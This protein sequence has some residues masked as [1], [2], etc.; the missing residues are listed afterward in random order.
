MTMVAKKHQSNLDR[1]KT[2]IENAYNYFKPNYDRWHE[3]SKF[4]FLTSL[5]AKDEEYLKMVGKPPLECNILEAFISRLRGEFYK[6]EPSIEVM[7]DNDTQVDPNMIKVVEGHIRHILTAANND[8]S[9]Y[10]AYTDML[11]GG[12]SVLEVCTEYSNPTSMNQVIKFGRAFDPTLCGFDPLAR[13]PHKGDGRYCFKIY[14][15]TKEEFEQEWEGVDIS[16]IKFDKA[17]EGFNWSYSTSKEDILLVVDYYE[18]KKRT[19]KIG[20]LPNGKTIKED[21]YKQM[22]EQWQDITQPPVVPDDKWRKTTIETICRYRLIENQIIEYIETDFKMLPLVFCDGNSVFLRDKGDGVLQQ[23]TRPY[24]YHAK[25]TQKLK[26]YAM[27]TWAA[28]LENMVMHKWIAA[29]EGIP[30]KQEFVKAYTNPQLPNNLIYKAFMDNDSSKPVPPPQVVVRAPMPPEIANALAMTD[31]L[32]QT[33]LGSYDASLGINDNQLSGVAIVE[34]ATQSNAAAMPY[35]VGFMQA[36]NQVAQIIIDLIPKYYVTPRTIPI[37]TAEGKKSYQVINQQG[38]M[39]LN[40]EENALNVKVEAG[41]NFAVQKDR[42]L[43][44]IIAAKQAS[45]IFAQFMDTMGL[46]VFMD[47]LEFKGSDVLKS[48][49]PQFLQQMAQQQKQQMMMAQQAQQNNPQ[50]MRA[51]NEKMKMQLD[52]QQNQVKNQLDAAGLQLQSTEIENERLR[53]LSE[54]QS[55]ERDALVQ[56]DKHETEKSRAAAELA[57]EVTRMH[58]EHNLDHVGAHHDHIEVQRKI[59]DTILTH[60]HHEA[61]ESKQEKMAEGE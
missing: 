42:A 61:T 3:W 12:F 28:E 51:Q 5:T 6:Q 58:H 20:M 35:V 14:P 30:E 50:I 43:N 55:N 26:N 32:T 54:M 29:E 10:V 47:N 39:Q 56:M 18:K 38:G 7:A 48:R 24:P 34:A 25:G 60:K 53:T 22:H 45:P 46:D 21:D 36:L 15:K 31:G 44:K 23:H 33:I 11:A 1:I 37:M 2:N 49:V 16:E 41:P 13:L 27:Q 9:E 17:I 40:Y 57:M 4:I 52:A 59:A 19:V 8:N